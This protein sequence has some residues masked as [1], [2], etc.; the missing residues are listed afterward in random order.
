M[1]SFIDQVN[2]L[3]PFTLSHN[4]LYQLPGFQSD[5]RHYLESALKLEPLQRIEEIDRV[6][7]QTKLAQLGHFFSV[8]LD[9]TINAMAPLSVGEAGVAHRFATVSPHRSPFVT[10]YDPHSGVARLFNAEVAL[11]QVCQLNLRALASRE[12]LQDR[13]TFVRTGKH[14]QHAKEVDNSISQIFLS[15]FF[16]DAAEEAP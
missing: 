12:E 11:F 16:Q 4:G 15:D 3:D 10:V 13:L 1:T 14:V 8:P 6:L 5:L 7:P 9:L 2:C